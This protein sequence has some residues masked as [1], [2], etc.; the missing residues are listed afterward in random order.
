MLTWLLPLL[1][2]VAIAAGYAAYRG[3]MQR[4]VREPGHATEPRLQTE[5]GEPPDAPGDQPLVPSHRRLAVFDTPRGPGAQDRRRCSRTFRTSKR[6]TARLATDT[7][8]LERH[9]LPCWNGEQD[10]ADAL[11]IPVGKL[12]AFAQHRRIERRPHY[13]AFP[14]AKKGGGTRLVHAPKRQLKEVQRH[15]LRLLI[16]KLPVHTAAHAF[17]KGRSIKTG[18]AAHVG[19]RVVLALDIR[20]FFPSL[21]FV[22]V[23]GYLIAMGYG[24]EVATTLAVLCTESER[25]PVEIDGGLVHVAVSPRRLPQGAPTSPGLANAICLRLDRRLSGLARAHGF[26]YTRYADDLTFSGDDDGA[27]GKLRSGVMSVIRQEGFEPHPDKT[28]VMRKG[29][30]QRVT[31]VTVNDTLGLSRQERRKIRAAIHQ[32]CSGPDPDPA[33]VRQLQG[34]LAHVRML[35][36]GQAASLERGWRFDFRG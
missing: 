14:I 26:A 28:R 1:A 4:S 22:R 10:V 19:K 8:Q 29:Q 35:H 34:H 6:K 32:A 33:R 31:G 17:H 5:P 16:G 9:G 13:V 3:W 21:T 36:P 20:E 15:L 2:V 11:G 30:R 27:V 12:R 24:Y 23:R 25:Q 7:R 18:A